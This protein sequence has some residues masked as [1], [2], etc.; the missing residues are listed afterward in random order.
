[1]KHIIITS[2]ALIALS[3]LPARSQVLA[4]AT[5]ALPLRL[6]VR[7]DS[8][9]WLEG[10]SNVRDWRCD[11]TTLD[12]SVDFADYRTNPDD[13]AAVAQLRHVQ[14]RVPTRALTCGRS[15]MDRIMYKALHADDE[16][17]CR[18]IIGRFDVMSRSNRENE[19]VMQ[20]TLRVAGRERSVRVP[21]ELERLR[22]GTLRARGALPILMTDYGIT[23]PSAF[24]GVLRTE[25]RIVV[26]F[27]LLIDEP[28]TLASSSA[29]DR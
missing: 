5:G 12:A 10:S 28:A 25:N 29:G 2:I 4:S 26:K 24:F 1:M 8:K 3:G 22:D 14:V 18:Q 15:Q 27:D 16:P 17:D 20:G 6:S 13:P 21:I 9:L 11:A 7:T 19:M 23:P